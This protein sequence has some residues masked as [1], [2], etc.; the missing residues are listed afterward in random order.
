M[1][2]TFA[3]YIADDE[4]EFE[5]TGRT[6]INPN[7]TTGMVNVIRCSDGATFAVNTTLKMHV[8]VAISIIMAS[9][10]SIGTRTNMDG[11]R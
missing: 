9:A 3:G 10:W 8:C 6:T 1:S 11:L 5:W 7:G 4:Y 2:A